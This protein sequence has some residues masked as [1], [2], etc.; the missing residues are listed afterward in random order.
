MLKGTYS[1]RAWA[2]LAF[3][4]LAVVAVSG[5]GED[6]DSEGNGPTNAQAEEATGTSGDGARQGGEGD[7]DG[8]GGAGDAAGGDGGS[9]V[10]AK[11]AA[12]ADAVCAQS[13][14]RFQR[15]AKKALFEAPEQGE[16]QAIEDVVNDVSI[17]RLEE[18]IADLRSLEGSP[19]D[20]TA[21]AE[22]AAG[23]EKAVVAIKA[24]PETFFR[25]TV[26][27]LTATR[28]TAVNFGFKRCG[29]LS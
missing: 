17:P 20:E 25:G 24:D 19:S 23:L 6:G 7:E 2:A 1:I 10:D 5:C 29:T 18:Q 27:E 22:V 11:F 15:E 28:R 16:E 3:T 8:Q 4:L 26:P 21:A 9:E 12:R 14:K 13:A